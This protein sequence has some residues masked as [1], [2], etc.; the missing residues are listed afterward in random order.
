MRSVAR[1]LLFD[2]FGKPSVARDVTCPARSRQ[3]NGGKR[4]GGEPQVDAV[5][6]ADVRR[7]WGI[8]H[9]ATL[10]PEWPLV[11]CSLCVLV[12]ASEGC[13]CALNSCRLSWGNPLPIKVFNIDLHRAFD[14]AGLGDLSDVEADAASDDGYLRGNSRYEDHRGWTWQDVR[15]ALDVET[16][17]VERLAAR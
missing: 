15:A 11:H 14:S 2:C 10:A 3:V 7:A 17:I 9:G 8:G 1:Q 16:S 4:P 6:I 13:A 12:N 5:Q